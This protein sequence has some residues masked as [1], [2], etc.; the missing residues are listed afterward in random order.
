MAEDI[1]SGF[2]INWI[3]LRDIDTGEILWQSNEDFSNP[4]TQYSI[5]L[6]KKVLNSVAV[7]REVNFSSI[8]EWK[9]LKLVQTFLYKG[10]ILDEWAFDYGMVTPNS[11]HSWQSVIEAAPEI[12]MMNVDILSGN[13]EIVSKFYNNELLVTTSKSRLYYE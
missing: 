2:Q 9:H 13:V 3:I 8:E 11:I 12:N 1:L 7:L 5:K 4:E 6:P 10:I